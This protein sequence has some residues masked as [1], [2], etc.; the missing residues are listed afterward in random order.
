[1]SS[2]EHGKRLPKGRKARRTRRS[3]TL[4]REM[5]EWKYRTSVVRRYSNI[6]SQV[7]ITLI[8][9]SPRP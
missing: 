4:F 9:D 8:G 7:V 2:L 6:A 5:H 1:M 3:E